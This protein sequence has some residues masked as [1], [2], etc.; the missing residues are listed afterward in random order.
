M[1]YT[2][3]VI[4]TCSVYIPNKA[5]AVTRGK[6]T[7]KRTTS[8]PYL[9]VLQ[10]GEGPHVE[11]GR[12][13]LRRHAAVELA[14]AAADGQRVR[15]VGAA[16]GGRAVQPAEVGRRAELCAHKR[17]R[18]GEVMDGAARG[19]N[20]RIQQ[21]NLFCRLKKKEKGHSGVKRLL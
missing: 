1:L 19:R 2:L 17:K 10:V 14:V 11:V 15:P 21:A 3:A 16:Q 5:Q 6:P 4:P 9:D 20:I 18:K 8:T 13:L 12:V 7:G